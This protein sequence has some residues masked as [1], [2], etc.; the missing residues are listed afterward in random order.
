MNILGAILI[1]L[2]GPLFMAATLLLVLP[3]NLF[4]SW[5]AS[6][7]WVMLVVPL[8][9]WPTLSW[10]VFFGIAAT[11]RVIH[12]RD[13]NQKRD[14]DKTDFEREHPWWNAAS[15]A[16]IGGFFAPILLYAGA[17]LVARWAL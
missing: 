16:M 3:F 5:I 17:W 8:T 6:K 2:A 4:Q 11:L 9:G 1:V 13:Y 14:E 12:T 7:I 10:A 15:M